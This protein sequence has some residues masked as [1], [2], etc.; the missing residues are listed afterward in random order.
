MAGVFR[1]AEPGSS[2]TLDRRACNMHA[3]LN[4]PCLSPAIFH[5]DIRVT[6][7]RIQGGGRVER[8]RLLRIIHGTGGRNLKFSTQVGNR[9]WRSSRARPRVILITSAWPRVETVVGQ[10]DELGE[11]RM[12]NCVENERRRFF[13]LF[14]DFLENERNGMDGMEGGVVFAIFE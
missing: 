10:F 3:P 14:N 7:I 8:V 1:G 4:I 12:V 2:R 11:G 9:G 5:R 6:V 13:F